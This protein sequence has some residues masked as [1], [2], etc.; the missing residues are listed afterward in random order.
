MNRSLWF[1]TLAAIALAG[2]ASA[3][4]FE[5]G[6]ASFKITNKLSAGA[7]MRVQNRDPDYVGIANGG[8][9][10]S[11]NTDDGN[12]AFDRGDLVTGVTKLTSDLAVSYGDFGLFVRGSGVYNPLLHNKDDYFNTANYGAGKEAPDSEHG[13]KT[14]KVSNYVGRRVDLLEAYAYGRFDVG[15]RALSVRL[16]RQT[17]NWGESL[18]IQHGLNSLMALDVNRLR[19]PGFEFEELTRPAAMAWMSMDLVANVGMDL[20]YQFEWRPTVI[21]ATGTYWSTNDFAGIG[22]NRVNLGFGRADENSPNTD[23]GDPTTWC[24]PPPEL[25]PPFGSPCNPFGSTVPRAADN[26]PSDTGQYGGVLHFYLQWL[27]DTSL[28]VYAANYHS[29]LPLSSGTSRE[30]GTSPASDANYFIEYPEN[31]RLYG[32]SF[33]NTIRLLDVAVQGEYSLK[34]GQPLQIEDVELLLAGLGAPS[35]LN[36]SAGATLGNQYLRGWRRFDVSQVNLSFTKVMT[37]TPVWDQLSM[38]VETGMT[39]VHDLPSAQVLAFEAPATY[40]LNPGTAAMNPGTAAGLP[41]TPYSDYATA[42]SWGYRAAGRLTYNNVFNLFTFEPALVFQHDLKGNTP[43]PI[44]NFIE[45]RKQATLVL[46]VDYLATWSAALGYTN[47]FGGGH[48]NLLNDRD[49]VE[50]NVK[51]AF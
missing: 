9:A 30:T 21:D 34:A 41:V 33:N 3:I 16:G 39:Y 47:Y 10:F 43:T 44:V 15:E 42:T 31:I 50:L 4:D 29:R 8:N 17:L 22:G 26:R 12:L 45:G 49:F 36:P 6:D 2:P 38:F 32:V 46:A 37:P 27:N 35:Q 11:T 18:L 48:Q 28:S 5:W 24:A 25:A 7:A 20:F 14:S 40:T 19:I 51:Y 1:P 23:P 13:E